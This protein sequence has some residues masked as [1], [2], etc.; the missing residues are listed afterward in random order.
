MKYPWQGKF[1]IQ[2]NDYMIQCRNFNQTNILN[3]ESQRRREKMFHSQTTENKISASQR[4]I[5]QMF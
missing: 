1:D 5:K 2:G 4:S 3:A